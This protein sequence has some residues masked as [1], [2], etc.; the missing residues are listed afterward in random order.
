VIWKNLWSQKEFKEKRIHAILKGLFKRP[1]N[2]EKD[3]IKFF[4]KYNLPYKYVGD[5]S[6]IIGGK[7]PDFVNINGEKKLVEIGNVFHHK[8]DYIEKRK[9]HFAKYG[10]QTYI[11]IGDKFNEEKMLNELEK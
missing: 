5:G 2:L 10:W 8:G 6:L 7:N 1:T 4:S 9:E 3:A 11:L